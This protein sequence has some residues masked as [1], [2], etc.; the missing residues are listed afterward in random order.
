ME[1][2]H[3]AR[4][5]VKLR[6]QQPVDGGGIP[7]SHLRKPLRRPS[8]GRG[9]LRLEPHRVKKIQNARHHGRFSRAR[10]ARH[11]KQSAL[12]RVSDRL[13]LLLRVGDLVLFLHACQYLRQTARR[14]DAHARH[15]RDARCNIPLRLV[16]LR[17]IARPQPRHGVL[18]HPPLLQK[19]LHPRLDRLRFQTEQRRRRGGQLVR[20]QKRVPAAK[21]IAQL[22]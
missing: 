1:K 4:L 13:L 2:R 19:A 17:Q 15:F 12:R 21:I 6:L 5:G 20:R 18:V 8:R 16:K 7:P 11:Q 22:K 10:S 14:L 3:R 9:K